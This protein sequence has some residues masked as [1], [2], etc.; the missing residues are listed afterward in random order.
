MLKALLNI[1]LVDLGL[2]LDGHLIWSWEAVVWPV[3]I[4]L[5]LSF[6][7]SVS[8]TLICVGQF[9]RAALRSD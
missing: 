7:G 9:F 6:V 3:Y 8:S 1:L 4:I 2:T 5:S